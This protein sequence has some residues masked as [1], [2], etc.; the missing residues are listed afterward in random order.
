ML[1]TLLTFTLLASATFASNN[2]TVRL[3]AYSNTA[4]LEKALSTY[5]PA[6]KETVHT[7]K[8]GKFT[9]AYTLPTNDKAT[10]KKLLPSYRKVFKDAYIISTR[11]NKGQLQK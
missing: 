5:P 9:Y 8:K 4:K 6:L 1:R 3:A 11:L 10:L 2:F 7:Y